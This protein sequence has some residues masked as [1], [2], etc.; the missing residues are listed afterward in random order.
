MSHA[1]DTEPALGGAPTLNLGEPHPALRATSGVV[2]SHGF[3]DDSSTFDLLLAELGDQHR[4][5][6]WD[7]PGHGC[8]PVGTRPA[9]RASALAGLQRAMDEAGPD[10]VTLIGHSLGGYLS[11]CQAVLGPQR[12]AGLVL[13]A[14]GPG[15]R[16]PDKRARWNK[17]IRTLANDRGV[18]P[19]A[20]AIGEQPDSLV[21]DGLTTLTAPTLIIVGSEDRAYHRGSAL[22]A[23][24]MPDATLLV[25]G[26][27]GHFPHRTHT[28]ETARA[29]KAHLS[30]G[31][32]STTAP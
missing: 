14:T 32:S 12:V 13:L 29:I 17:R 21:L 11:L 16:D 24:V 18:P 25:I 6:T 2:C 28:A 27:A 19:A 9:S 7:L 5:V 4:V 15:F 20:A 23:D 22:M 31:T 10:P 26:G 8:S 3:A 1:R 30:S